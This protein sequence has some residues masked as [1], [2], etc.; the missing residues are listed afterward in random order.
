MFLLTSVQTVLWGVVSLL[1][2]LVFSG[3]PKN[4]E[5]G[6]YFLSA[7]ESLYSP[8]YFVADSVTQEISREQYHLLHEMGWPVIDPIVSSGWGNR[9]ASCKG[10]SSYH[11]G[12]DFVPGR[13]TPVLAAMRGVV[14]TVENSG[15]YGVHVII[16]HD[17]HSQVWH[18]VYAH[19]E[20]RS[21]PENIKPGT[22]VNIG[23]MVGR[24]GST[25]TST[26]PHLHFEVRIDGIKVNPMP[27]L[28]KN[29]PNN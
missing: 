9:E 7:E 20:K 12:V 27:L 15:G 28:N 4:L 18:T 16:E 22:Y 24:V 8:K 11:T 2:P 14:H 25:G 29:I 5:F 3:L 17:L 1:L 13:S 10:C 21:V 19:L 23:D 26:G 6:C